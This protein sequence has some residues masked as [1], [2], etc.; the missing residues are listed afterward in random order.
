[1]DHH[2]PCS[3]TRLS[4]FLCYNAPDDV[5]SL[6]LVL[7]RSATPRSPLVLTQSFSSY[8]CDFFDPL[9]LSL[10]ERVF[11]VLASLSANGLFSECFHAA[12]FVG[13]LLFPASVL[14]TSLRIYRSLPQNC[15]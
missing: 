13:L 7:N 2:A 6:V 10:F 8:H 9:S 5:F 14:Y 4:S 15:I 3:T 11:H 12:S 1:M